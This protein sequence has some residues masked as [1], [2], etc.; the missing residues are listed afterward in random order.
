MWIHCL[1][2]PCPFVSPGNLH[3][4]MSWMC[5]NG[6]SNDH[7]SVLAMLRSH[8]APHIAPRSEE[9]LYGV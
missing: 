7:R 6:A 8:L 2:H 4:S 9:V 1:C 3:V 5:Y